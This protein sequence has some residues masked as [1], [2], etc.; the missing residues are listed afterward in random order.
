MLFLDF[1]FPFSRHRYAQH[2]S[3][4]Q[5]GYSTFSGSSLSFSLLTTHKGHCDVRRDWNKIA[6]W[7]IISKKKKNG[8]RSEEKAKMQEVS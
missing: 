5:H 3:L 4:S 8:V 6:L 2:L 1:N 7:G